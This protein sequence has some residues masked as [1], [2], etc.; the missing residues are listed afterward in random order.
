MTEI[1]YLDIE[2]EIK[3]I[4][5]AD[6]TTKAIDHL[7]KNKTITKKLRVQVEETFNVKPDNTPW[8][9]V[10][11]RD[12]D[13]PEEEEKIGGASPIMTDLGIE[14]WLY[15]FSFDNRN[16]ASMRD[17]LRRKV[18]NVLKGNRSLNSK[19][20]AVRFDGGSFD[21]PIEDKGFFKGVSIKLRCELRE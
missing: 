9:G 1:N 10:F 5:L 4:L 12:Y 17:N 8:V 13:T 6:I 14:L 19:V 18:M 15:V 16:A 3:T 2:D 21:T 7:V 20:L 11:L